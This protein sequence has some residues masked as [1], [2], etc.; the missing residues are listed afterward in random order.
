MINFVTGTLVERNK[1]LS[2]LGFMA[3]FSKTLVNK[4]VTI[5]RDKYLWV[6]IAKPEITGNEF[7]L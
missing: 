2:F 1:F 5:K 7:T 3:K 4:N 6:F